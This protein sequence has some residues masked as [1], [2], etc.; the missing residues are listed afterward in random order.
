MS[1]NWS[2]VNQVVRDALNDVRLED[3]MYTAQLA[4]PTIQEGVTVYNAP[5]TQ[6]IE[7]LS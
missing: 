1:Q 6:Q 5:S 3:L 7:M 2:C 4:A